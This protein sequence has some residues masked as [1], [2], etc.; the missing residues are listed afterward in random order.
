MDA[1]L[2]EI[3]YSQLREWSAFFAIEPWGAEVEWARTGVIAS[4]VFNMSPSR[5]PRSKPMSPSDFMPEFEI[6]K[7][8]KPAKPL[9]KG[10]ADVAKFA[11]AF[12]GEGKKPS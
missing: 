6:A 4:T 10:V 1:L 8:G 3:R 12:G 7:P 5:K 2:A 11:A 9:A